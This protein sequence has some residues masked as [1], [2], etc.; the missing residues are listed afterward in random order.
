LGLIAAHARDAWATRSAAAGYGVARVWRGSTL[1]VNGQ[2][3]RW[4][5][6]I[7]ALSAAPPDLPN[8][9]PPPMR[10]PRC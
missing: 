9:R 5:R 4:R 1:A 8:R 6:P 10:D 2:A 7:A 3:A